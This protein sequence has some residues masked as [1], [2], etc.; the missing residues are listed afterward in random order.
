MGNCACF[1]KEALDKAPVRGNIWNKLLSLKK[2]VVQ[3]CQGPESSFLSHRLSLNLHIAT[4]RVVS[5]EDSK[6]S[7]EPK[8][9]Y[10]FWVSGLTLR[11]QQLCLLQESKILIISTILNFQLQQT[12]LY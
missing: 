1:W 4:K 7:P 5:Q 6:W 12:C 2:S 11:T 8:R 9:V 10:G 3:C